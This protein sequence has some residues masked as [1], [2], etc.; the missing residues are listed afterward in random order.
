MKQPRTDHPVWIIAGLLALAGL[1]LFW[2][3]AS[4]V[5]VGASVA[6]I[7]LPVHHRFS[8]S[9]RPWLSA[10]VL[11]AGVC[12]ILLAILATM[13][14]VFSKN[15]A[16]LMAI[17]DTIRSWL[18]DPSTNPLLA[19]DQKISPSTASFFR[20]QFIYWLSVAREFF[21]DFESTIILNGT[22]I[23]I[24]ALLFFI[25]VFFL[26]LYGE[27]LKESVF[28]RIPFLS[29]RKH[30]AR[31]SSVTFDT[32]HVIYV[33]QFSI[34]VLTFF[35]SLPVFY[36]L[37][38]G[39]ILFYSF[40]AAFCELIPVFGST[41]AF[42][43]IGAYA[44]ALGDLQGVL[45]LFFLGY[46]GV[47]ALP[48]IFIRPVLMGRRAHVHPVVMFTGF[49]GGILTMGIAGFVLGP[50]ILVLLITSY[51]I[52]REEKSVTAGVPG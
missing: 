16:P 28:L 1:V 12:C 17:L 37:G 49:M 4:M 19:V 42:I 18:T 21:V 40:F 39:N 33:A 45:I 51:R 8:R 44:L 47:A 20:S 6:V 38:Y 26:L 11:T 9:V 36:L 7:L 43:L 41:V 50:L 30:D 46:I 10:A 15:S 2:P 32:L 31:L 27:K 25:S 22:R 5:I 3:F 35:I 14:F 13:V 24:Q 23:A 29:I 52:Y 48:E 34:A